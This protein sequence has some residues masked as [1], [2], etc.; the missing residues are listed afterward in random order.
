M[1]STRHGRP[2]S[3]EPPR[4]AAVSFDDDNLIVM[5]EDGRSISVP[6]EWFPSLRDATQAQRDKWEFIGRGMGI[7]WEDIDEDLSVRGLLDPARF[8]RLRTAV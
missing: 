7:H 3:T 2:I 4:A 1:N 6:L 5:L 8:M